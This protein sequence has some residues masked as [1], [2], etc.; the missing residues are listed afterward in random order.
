MFAYMNWSLYVFWIVLSMYLS[1]PNRFHLDKDVPNLHTLHISAELE[2]DR[3]CWKSN[4]NHLET[5]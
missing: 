4:H 2:K 1:L 5:S 3:L